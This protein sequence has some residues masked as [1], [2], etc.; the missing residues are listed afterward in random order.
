MTTADKDFAR[1]YMN[2]PIESERQ[3]TNREIIKCFDNLRKRVQALEDTNE[4]IAG[5]LR[6]VVKRWEVK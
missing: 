3:M 4:Q 1:E 6:L 2:G 5:L